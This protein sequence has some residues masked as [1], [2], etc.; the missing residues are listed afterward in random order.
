MA[1]WLTFFLAKVEG[2]EGNWDLT[3]DITD[4]DDGTVI[5]DLKRVSEEREPR[6]GYFY[7]AHGPG[8]TTMCGG[9]KDPEEAI[10][11]GWSEFPDAEYIE[12][13]R[14]HGE[15]EYEES[16]DTVNISMDA[17]VVARDRENKKGSI[18]WVEG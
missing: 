10:E 16:D 18:E 2:K 4:D 7:I 6:D 9:Y 3:D 11:G 15:P 14:F 13:A 5:T 17:V 12:A 8:F 1:S